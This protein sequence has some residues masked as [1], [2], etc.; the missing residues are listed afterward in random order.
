[1][2][3]TEQSAPNARTGGAINGIAASPSPSMGP[4][5]G[6][7]AGIAASTAENSSA[8]GRLND[9]I[10]AWCQ[11]Q[12]RI[13]RST[14]ERL[15]VGS[16]TIFFPD[17]GQKLPAI[18]FRY[19][20]GWKA[21][22]V[23]GKH[24]VAGKGF[25]LAFWNIASVASVGPSTVY[26]TE[27]ELDAA[28]LVEAGVP[29]T[30]VL[31]VPNGAKERPAEDPE[32]QRGYDYVRDALESG[33]N[34][35]KKIVWCGDGD[36]PGL[37]LRQDM[38]RLFGPA[39]FY[40]VDWPEGVKDANQMLMT[41]GP[42]AL[43]DLVTNGHLP[44]PVAGLYR[45]SEL[46]EP[47]PMVLWNPGFPDWGNRVRLA[48]RNIS[49][50]TGHP[51]HGKALALNTPIPT[52]GGWTTMGD[53]KPGDTIF[54]ESG[55]TCSVTLV[56]PVY[57]NHDCYKVVFDDGSEII[58]DAE[59]LW[60]TETEAARQS[61][62][63]WQRR[64]ARNTVLPRGTD[65]SDKRIFPYVVS[66]REIAST[67]IVNGKRNHAVRLSKPIECPEKEL[68]IPPYTLG[69]WLGDGTSCAAAITCDD[70]DAEIMEHVA[71]DEIPVLRQ[72]RKDRPT[73]WSLSDGVKNPHK[74]CVSKRLRA[75]GLWDNKHIPNDYLRA[76]VGQRL[77]L[78][79]GLMD[80]DGHFSNGAAEFCTTS[81]V[82]ADG[83][84]ELVCSLGIRTKMDEGRASIYGR[85][86]GEKFRIRFT[87]PLQVFKLSRKLAA[88]SK[89]T[90]RRKYRYIVSCDPVPTVP[91]RCIQV[92]SPNR[93]YLAGRSFIAT[94]NT[95][96]WTQIW[97][98]IV[99]TYCIPMAVATFETRAKPHYRR[100]LRTLFCGGLEKNLTDH[101]ISEADKFIN[102]RYVF[103]VHPDQRPTLQWF[104]DC[105]EVAVVRHGV[106]IIQLDPWNRME[107][108]REAR[109][110][111]TDYIGR[112][113]REI[114]SFA[115]DMNCH[116]Q[117]LAHPAKM[118][119]TRRGQAP[120]LEDISGSKNWENM[121]D[122]G[123]VVHRPE[124][125]D[126][127]LRKT[128]AALYHRKARFEELGF[129]C[130][131]MMNFDLDRGS[132]VSIPEGA[133]YP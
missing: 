97:F 98:N 52:P 78:L 76:S 48:Q 126:G 109:E 123:F 57:L 131:L 105:A 120:G 9:Q 36:G 122:Q 89:V 107:A 112:C 96:L 24:F 28:A 55:Q 14:L 60:L 17:A 29:H 125:F 1:M 22:A 34:R 27:G 121:V 70:R 104:L 37:V 68:P 53:I 7:I 91:V 72:P 115:H 127:S 11:S 23:T 39:R 102:D 58:A 77:E 42:E 51:G 45:M 75:M 100:M 94:H 4:G 128:E 90:G 56:T 82:L 31:S 21:R 101:E 41:D 10:A 8:A 5:S 35:A 83:V 92:D 67:L 84:Y 130:K 16:G 86:C 32:Q 43:L 25:T 133:K 15:G 2:E 26:I 108:Q 110:S 113:L 61:E 99:R 116:V 3:T 54:D 103:F 63:N 132:Y 73:H 62:R 119:G 12:R 74:D 87:T 33:L 20:N 6:G 117:I 71:A 85:D 106:R 111:E 40:F 47:P 50:V 49:V 19:P 95:A 64:G 66:T 38:A 65:Q 30:A 118:E 46:P 124:I 81:R 80:T 69:A 13:S 44:W 114:H 88:Q 93:L 18:V 79:R 59:H 129:P